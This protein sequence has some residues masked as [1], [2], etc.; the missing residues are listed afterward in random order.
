MVRGFNLN[1][2]E[3]VIKNIGKFDP[4]KQ[5]PL[6]FWK[7]LEQYSDVYNF[8]DGDACVVL[9]LCLPNTLC[10]ALH[11]KVKVRTANTLERK[12]GLLEVL[13]MMSVDWDKIA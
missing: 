5:N 13:G 8:T 2:L 12:Q 7:N 3:A 9:A 4:I 11:E 10:G 6:E 1:K